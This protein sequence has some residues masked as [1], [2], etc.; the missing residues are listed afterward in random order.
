MIVSRNASW[1]YATYVLAR[2]AENSAK[3]RQ[4]YRL[5]PSLLMR[6]RYAALSLF[7][8]YRSNFF[9][10]PTITSSPR[11]AIWSFLFA[12]ICSVSSLMRVVNASTCTAGEPVSTTVFCALVLARFAFVS[13]IV[14]CYFSMSC[15]LTQA[16]S[17]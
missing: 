10:R 15:T 5:K 3:M 11:R 4:I 2:T 9:R 17:P 7:A 13:V 16:A 8:K 1:T 14:E 12:F 6:E